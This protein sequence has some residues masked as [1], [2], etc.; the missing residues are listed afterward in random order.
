MLLGVI[1]H[2][3]NQPKKNRKGKIS[4]AQKNKHGYFKFEIE[5]RTDD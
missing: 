4:I 3:I 2:F 1:Y 5:Y